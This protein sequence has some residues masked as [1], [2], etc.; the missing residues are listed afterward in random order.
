M[1]LSR[2]VNHEQAVLLDIRNKDEFDAGHIAKSRNIPLQDLQKK[3]RQL[4]KFK[5]RPMVIISQAGRESGK[6][7]N[8]LRKLEFDKLFHLTGGLVEWH[9]DNLPLEKSK[10]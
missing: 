6:A 4:E 7:A 8:Q 5:K 10:S 3:S 9:K 1:E 2:L